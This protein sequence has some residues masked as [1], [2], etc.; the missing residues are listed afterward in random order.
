MTP[1]WAVSRAL[2]LYAPL[3][4]NQSSFKVAHFPHILPISPSLSMTSLPSFIE[5]MESLG[6]EH[7]HSP[8]PELSPSPSPEYSPSSSPHIMAPSRARSSPSL[9]DLSPRRQTSRYSPYSSSSRRGSTSSSS[10]FECSKRQLPSPLVSS[11]RD[12]RSRN[13]LT[14]NVYG[15]TSDLPAYAPISSYVRRKTPG[16][17]PTSPTFPRHVGYESVDITLPM[18]PSFPNSASTDSSFPKTP[19]SESLP[20]PR[21]SEKSSIVTEIDEARPPTSHRRWH[22][23]VRL[24]TSPRS[25]GLDDISRHRFTPNL[26]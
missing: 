16:A 11:L 10:D 19:K 4:S 12:R 9:K 13:Q 7:R 21:L 26:A 17:S 14:V 1:P 3:R 15:S 25:A 22:T 20:S 5:L 8:S 24:S 18:V 6:L 2:T 23:G